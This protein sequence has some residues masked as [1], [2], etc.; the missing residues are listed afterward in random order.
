MFLKGVYQF[1]ILYR[2]IFCRYPLPKLETFSKIFWVLPIDCNLYKKKTILG[3]FACLFI[4][5]VATIKRHFHSL[6]SAVKLQHVKRF[7]NEPFFRKTL[8]SSFTSNIPVYIE[9]NPVEIFCKILEIEIKT[10]NPVSPKFVFEKIKFKFLHYIR[11]NFI[12][13]R[14]G[15]TNDQISMFKSLNTD[16]FNLTCHQHFNGYMKDD[17][18]FFTK[19]KVGAANIL[20]KLNYL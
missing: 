5:K 11:H 10:C 19:V 18:Y 13:S 4:S 9:K 17:K 2:D 7:A 3:I 1:A 6:N 8:V 15:F 12:R 14:P 20:L 16:Y